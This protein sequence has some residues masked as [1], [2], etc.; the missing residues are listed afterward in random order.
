MYF[1][2]PQ[3]FPITELWH[4]FEQFIVH[5]YPNCVLH[6]GDNIYLVVSAFTF[7]QTSLAAFNSLCNII[8]VTVTDML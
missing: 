1:P 7:R 8:I 3:L 5:V 2:P 6:S 4:S